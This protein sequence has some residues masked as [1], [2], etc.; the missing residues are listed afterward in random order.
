MVTQTKSSKTDHKPKHKFYFPEK[1]KIVT[2]DSEVTTKVIVGDNESEG[3]YSIIS[4]L[5]KVG[6]SV[7]LHYHKKHF[8]TFY[9][10][11]GEAEWTV[12]GE[13]HQMKAGDAVYIPANAP[14]RAKTLGDKPAHFILIYSAGDYVEHLERQLAYTEEE[15]KDPK[16]KELLWKLNDFHILS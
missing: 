4:G 12:N 8:E 1:A 3:R 5:W 7:P 9:L 16:I 13:T 14:H 11:N 10:L 15:R 6:F 2:D